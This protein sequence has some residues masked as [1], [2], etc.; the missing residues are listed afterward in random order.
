M[1]ARF[2]WAWPRWSRPTQG[3]GRHSPIRPR[4]A[5]EQLEDRCTPAVIT[6]PT[7][8]PPVLASPQVATVAPT[9]PS[10]T[11]ATQVGSPQLVTQTVNPNNTSPGGILGSLTLPTGQF[12]PT[13]LALQN[14]P[15]VSPSQVLPPSAVLVAP[16]APSSYPGRLVLAG[17]GVVQ[18]VATG[19]GPLTQPPGLY[20]PGGNNG[21]AP[22]GPVRARARPVAPPSPPASSAVSMSDSSGTALNPSSNSETVSDLALSSFLDFFSYASST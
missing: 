22:T 3:Q 20:L 4:P 9:V 15:L 13:F 2:H 21:L 14:G 7:A 12:G 1:I 18:R 17:T 10:P 11:L 16:V 8:A 5:L 19:D 6:Q